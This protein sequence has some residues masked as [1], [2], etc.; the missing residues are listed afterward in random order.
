MGEGVAPLEHLVGVQGSVDAV[1][2]DGLT[3]L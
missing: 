2:L 3:R 1:L